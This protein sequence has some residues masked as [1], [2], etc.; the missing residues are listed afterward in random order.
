VGAREIQNRI[1]EI[2][3]K[4]NAKFTENAL[5]STYNTFKTGGTC[6]LLIDVGS[7]EILEE[8]L[9]FF[10]QNDENFFVLGNGS[11]VIVP[12]DGYSG[13]VLHFGNS[14]AK[15]TVNADEITCQAGA[16]LGAVCNTALQHGL[17]GLEF[18]WGIPGTIGGA[19]YMNAGAYSG[20]MKDVVTS[21]TC[22]KNGKAAE[23]SG[24]NLCLSYRSSV[25]ATD[26]SLIITDVKLKLKQD[27]K[28]AI[29]SR[30]DELLQKRHTSQPI[31]FPSAGSTFKRP[32]GHFAAA[33]IEQCGLKGFSVGGAE[34]SEKHSGFV[35]NKNNATTSDI[36]ALVTEVK[37][38][39]AEKTGVVLELE[40]IIMQ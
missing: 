12:D 22:L 40:P 10:V 38:I 26:K 35:I 13:T 20:E 34:I 3:E 23:I 7:H 21:A 16:S 14:F 27:E 2:C 18:A 15:I 36:L 24:E 5:L 9:A 30:M 39:V 17:S 25:F 4:H 6:P 11:N 31:D 29:K 1:I 28:T 8:L 19:L 37:K 32:V 33:L